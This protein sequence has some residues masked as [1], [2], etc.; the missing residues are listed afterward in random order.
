VVASGVSAA[1][2]AEA[3]AILG[4]S[5][6]MGLLILGITYPLP[7]KKLLGLLASADEVV[8]YEEITSFVEDQVLAL[9]AQHGPTVGVIRFHGKNSGEVLG[10]MGP[11]MGELTPESVTASLAAILGAAPPATGFA[12]EEAGQALAL[13]GGEMPRREHT[14]CAG[15]P[16]RASFWSLKEVLGAKGGQAMITGD[17]GCY[18]LALGD[19]GYKVLK[20]VHCMGAGLGMAVGMGQLARFGLENPVV[21]VIG[22]GT[23]FHAGLPA[24]INARH[25]ES[26]LLLI[27]LDNRTTAMTGHQPH[28][29]LPLDSV[30][31]PASAVELEDLM[32]GL[33]V[34]CRV[35]DPYDLAAA[36]KA[37][38]EMLAASGPRALVMRRE[39]SLSASRGR[40]RRTYHVET[41][42]CTGCA[43]CAQELACPA[44]R[45]D[46]ENSTADIDPALCV[47]CGV[48]AELCPAGA[49]VADQ[50]EARS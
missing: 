4:L 28:P 33:D 25:Q 12:E 22:D 18:T 48:C 47:G 3:L 7:I 27:I 16:H 5:D 49:I 20:T 44:A 39:C 17:I 26:D 11:G 41:E 21:A 29:G 1:Y 6:Q 13:L 42:D 46:A 32:K 9:A 2:A 14:F 19:T 36:Q 43:L 15:C 35:V 31:N 34:P 40:E 23:F 45:W 10:S 24:L 37:L 38:R 50:G 8:F 30:G